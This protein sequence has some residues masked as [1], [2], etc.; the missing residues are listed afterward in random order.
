M[1]KTEQRLICCN[2]K[3]EY[4]KGKYEYKGVINIPIKG[5][6]TG[7]TINCEYCGKEIYQTKTQYNRAKHHFC[8]NVCHKNYERQFIFE[9]R[10]CPICNNIFE[11]SKKSKQKFCSVQCQNKWQ[12]TNIG[13]KNVRFESKICTCDWCHTKIT[14]GKSNV[15][16]FHYHFCSDACRKQWYSNIYSQSEEW[17]EESRIRATKILENRKIDTNT[18]PQVIINQTLDEMNIRYTNEKN[19]KYYSMDNYLDDYQLSIEVMGDFWHTNPIKYSTYPTSNIQSNRIV[20]DK[21]KHKY[22]KKYF[23]HEILYLWEDDIYNNLLLCKRLIQKYISTNGILENY[24]SF[25]YHLE[26]DSIVL[27]SSIILPYF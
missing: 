22:I 7:Y 5:Q 18:K 11:A 24:H 27:N 3:R 23:N 26:N 15:K 4:I 13:E 10:T 9:N 20:K 19:F 21:A 17:K 8:S 14:V 25:N 2:I 1:D 12:K 6:R 16:R